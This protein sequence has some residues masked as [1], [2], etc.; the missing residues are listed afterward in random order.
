MLW[1]IIP[2][3]VVALLF[4]S[5]L[6]K[7]ALAVL[8]ASLAAGVTLYVQNQQIE[9][10]ATSRIADA[11]VELANVTVRRTFDW[12]YELSGRVRNNS[13]TYAIDGMTFTVR[14][15]DC[16]GTAPVSCVPL[17]EGTLNVPVNVPPEQARDFR[18]SFL[19]GKREVQP[20][21]T[22]AWD[23]EMTAISAKRR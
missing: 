7:I 4:A 14:L 16:R 10:R 17:G 12:S 22:L 2:L 20:K 6:R 19:I 5:G 21:G 13:P 3:V 15:R 9:R 18:G 11:E 23:Y 8:V 1:L